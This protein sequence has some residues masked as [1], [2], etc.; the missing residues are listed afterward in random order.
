MRKK[1]EVEQR[2]AENQAKARAYL[3]EWG[4]RKKRKKK[5]MKKLPKSSRPSR[6]RSSHMKFWTYSGPTLRAPCLPVP[7]A[8][9]VSGYMCMRWIWRLCGRIPHNF[10]VPLDIWSLF[11]F[12]P[13]FRQ[14]LE[15]FDSGYKFLRRVEISRI[16]HVKMDFGSRGPCR[17]LFTPGNLDDFNEPLCFWQSA[18]SPR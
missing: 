3:E 8:W 6:T 5:R 17:V 18:A 10:C 7:A 4:K 15:T 9:F 14:S 11:L 16:F 13:C 12:A 2:R 1:E